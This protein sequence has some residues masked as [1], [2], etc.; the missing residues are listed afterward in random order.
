MMCM[1]TCRAFQFQSFFWE[2][3][4]LVS[5][6]RRMVLSQNLFDSLTRSN[7]SHVLRL[8]ATQIDALRVDKLPRH[9]KALDASDFEEK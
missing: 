2:V 4:V 1:Q 7:T 8:L 3:Q 9:F 5:E 6:A